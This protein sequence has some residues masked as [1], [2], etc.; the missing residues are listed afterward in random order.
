MAP[1]Q[2]TSP[3]LVDHRAD[4]Y[5]L[6]VVFYQML[7]GELPTGKFAPPS[8][9]VHID[10]RLDEIVLRALEQN[11]ELRYQNATQ[12]KTEIETVANNPAI[13][14]PPPRGGA[15]VPSHTSAPVAQS[16]RIAD[17]LRIP[18]IGLRIASTLNLLLILVITA[19]I[20]LSRIFAAPSGG[21]PNIQ[22]SE[23]ALI[24]PGFLLNTF[25]LRAAI[26]RRR[27]RNYSQAPSPPASS[28]SSPSPPT[29]SASP[30]PS[31]P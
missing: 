22:L 16:E 2:S 10:I 15:N 25:I 30:S 27:L 11:P 3:D 26:N 14:P 5:A 4:I 8:K 7:T 31:G 29:C 17:S 23:L 20:V 24:I 6:G 19:P 21:M 28:P 13:N 12:F 18:A 1:E 9:K